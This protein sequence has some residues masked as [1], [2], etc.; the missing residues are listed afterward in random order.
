MD[1][2][3]QHGARRAV[4]VHGDDVATER[5]DDPV[6]GS[7]SFRTLL[8]GDAPTGPMTVG[9]NELRPGDWMG[10]HRHAPAEIY[11]VLEGEGVLVV[12]GEQH[13]LRPGHTVLVPGDAEH[14]LRCTGPGP[15]RI[16]YVFAVSSFAE[17]EYH[18]RDEPEHAPRDQQP[19]S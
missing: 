12:E 15:L 7:L 9:T 2:D 10:H 19:R 3:E 18:F 4:V 11:H 16:F 14:G 6:R 8:G 13:R 1:Q 5:W 17:V